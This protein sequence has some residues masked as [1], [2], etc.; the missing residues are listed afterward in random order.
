MR[1]RARSRARL[2]VS[3][4]DARGRSMVRGPAA[5]LAAWLPR[6]APPRASGTVA[7][8]VISDAAMRRL[9]RRHRGLDR[10]TDVLSF[11]GETGF[12]GDIA[13][14]SGVASRQARAAGHPLTTE[15]RVLAL[16]GL[17]HLLGYDHE[18]DN[19][20]MERV[21]ERLRRRAGLPGGLIGRARAGGSR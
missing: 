6:A 21:E 19:G 8:A 16:H 18:T 5:G 11:P 9:N 14:A 17:L 7:I 12:L 10:P 20:R 13:I 2:D 4:T 15:L 1:S 3:V